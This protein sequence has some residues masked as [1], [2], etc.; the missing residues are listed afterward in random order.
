MSR[1]VT[2]PSGLAFFVNQPSI[3][4]ARV[5]IHL[6]DIMRIPVIM[7]AC[8][9]LFV[10][11]LE[12]NDSSEAVP[13]HI[14]VRRHES[15]ERLLGPNNGAESI[16]VLRNARCTNPQVS[17]SRPQLASGWIPGDNS[18]IRRGL[19]TDRDKI[20]SFVDVKRAR[21]RAVR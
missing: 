17:N 21:V 3:I 20:S 9:V 5:I 1:R 13:L 15:H 6:Q 18:H 12:A 7:K 11:Y 14:S 16:L 4:R 10:M 19:I 2:V 8:I